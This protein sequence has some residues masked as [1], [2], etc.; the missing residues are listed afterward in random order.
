MLFINLTVLLFLLYPFP[1]NCYDVCSEH[2][3]SLTYSTLLSLQFNVVA[4]RVCS[5]RDGL[6][7]NISRGPLRQKDFIEDNRT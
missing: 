4:V 3:I 1:M 6:R 5:N 7:N 2:V